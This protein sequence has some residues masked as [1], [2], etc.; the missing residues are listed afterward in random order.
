MLHLTGLSNKLFSEQ[1][2]A[3]ITTIIER[4][5]QEKNFWETEIRKI[6]QFSREEAISELI[7]AKKIY[8]K[9][10]QI[11]TYIKGLQR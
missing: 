3:Q 11:D 2:S 7:K 5:V 10:A 9:I 4:G 1:L 6:E 8:E